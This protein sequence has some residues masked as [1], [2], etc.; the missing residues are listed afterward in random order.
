MTKNIFLI[1]L[2]TTNSLI[3]M[4]IIST[5]KPD[6]KKYLKKCDR[7]ARYFITQLPKQLELSEKLSK[8][9]ESSKKQTLLKEL[10][11]LKIKKLS[12]AFD[13][14]HK[15]HP[16]IQMLIRKHAL[17]NELTSL[18]LITIPKDI[19]TAVIQSCVPQYEIK[20]KVRLDDSQYVEYRNGYAEPK[21]VV[22]GVIATKKSDPTTELISTEQAQ[23]KIFDHNPIDA[24]NIFSE[25]KN[26]TLI[27]IKDLV[28][29]PSFGKSS[30]GV[31]FSDYFDDEEHL[32]KSYGWSLNDFI[33]TTS[34]QRKKI[35]E[36]IAGHTA[37]LSSKV[38]KRYKM[39]PEDIQLLLPIR[40]L[41][42]GNDL[43]KYLQV[44]VAYEEPTKLEK[45]KDA[46]LFATPLAITEGVIPHLI[47]NNIDGK[48]QGVV[49]AAA[50]YGSGF[51]VGNSIFP[52]FDA[53]NTNAL[54]IHKNFGPD[55]KTKVEKRWSFAALSLFHYVMH[56]LAEKLLSIPTLSY[57]AL[58]YTV[59][60]L[61][62]LSSIANLIDIRAYLGYRRGL[63][64][65]LI[66]GFHLKK[67]NHPLERRNKDDK[68]YTLIDLLN[69]QP[70][71]TI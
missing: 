68:S 49:G 63:L 29:D 19:F 70:K 38:D 2:I 33:Q 23:Q 7:V 53:W 12:D 3:G 52:L 37:G 45:V 65:E 61:R 36:I 4:E 51:I 22:L 21:K 6:Q 54:I 69:A 50:S 55:N 15:L 13:I 11:Q 39:T 57:Q 16:P 30:C 10:E 18:I 44:G 59:H 5:K 20:K 48:L 31:S 43:F 32:T 35:E 8:E 42:N 17:E 46:L 71:Q 24:L 62:A 28:E 9:L 40:D 66:S 60:G 41:I 58:G 14:F 56:A 64:G 47:Y 1:S 27:T 25:Y 67:Y 26:Q 34:A